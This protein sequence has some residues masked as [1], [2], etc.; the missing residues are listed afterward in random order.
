MVTVRRRLPL[1]DD[2]HRITQHHRKLVGF[3]TEQTTNIL[4][5]F[6]MREHHLVKNAN[7]LCAA[8]G[9]SLLLQDVHIRISLA[10]EKRLVAHDQSCEQVI[11]DI[12]LGLHH[13]EQ[14][15]IIDVLVRRTTKCTEHAH[16]RNRLCEPGQR[17]GGHTV[18]LTEI[19]RA[20]LRLRILIVLVLVGNHKKV[21]VRSTARILGHRAN[22]SVELIGSLEVCIALKV[23]GCRL[24][25]GS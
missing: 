22:P 18:V 6:D 19:R 21:R 9:M 17:D 23:E 7:H 5:T 20:A 12:A 1:Q 13:I 11:V 25:T 15:Q 24:L 8:A 3:T 16:Q 2:V 14:S 4:A 10:L